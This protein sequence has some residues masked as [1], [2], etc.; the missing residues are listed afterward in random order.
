MHTSNSMSKTTVQERGQVTI[1]KGLRDR[2]GIK[3]GAVLEFSAEDGRLVAR[4][5]DS[6]DPIDQI[7]GLSGSARSTDDVLSE[8]RGES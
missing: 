7:Y 6:F 1:P 3:P 2:L 8:L 5:I 4:K